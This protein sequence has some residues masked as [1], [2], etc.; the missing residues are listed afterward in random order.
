VKANVKAA[1]AKVGQV[2]ERDVIVPA[3]PTGCDPGQTNWFQ[4]LNV[5]TKIVKGQIE[6]V[7]ELKLITKGEKVGASEAGLLQKLNILPF[8][9]GV[10][11]LHVFMNG[12]VFDSLTLVRA[13][14]APNS[15]LV[16]VCLPRSLL[17]L[18]FPHR[19]LFLTRLDALLV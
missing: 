4:A 15:S 13:F 3:G 7:S 6:I 16:S 5:P 12:S 2:A 8:T 10:Q 1:P 18:E 9:Y 19:R 11:F 14:C 17:V